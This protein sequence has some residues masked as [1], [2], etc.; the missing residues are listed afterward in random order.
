MMMEDKMYVAIDLSCN[1]PLALWRLGVAYVVASETCAFN[2]IRA[3]FEREIVPVELL[4]ISDEGIQS[5]QFK[6]PKKRRLCSMEYVYFSRPDSDLNHSNVHTSRKNMG[7][8]LAKEAPVR[9]A[10]VVT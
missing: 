1:R 8:E 6:E 4:I 7:I 3:T 2:I 10:D 9:D 5:K